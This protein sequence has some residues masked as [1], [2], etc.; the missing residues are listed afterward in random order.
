VETLSPVAPIDTLGCPMAFSLRLCRQLGSRF[1]SPRGHLVTTTSS[2]GHESQGR[3]AP[4]NLIQQLSERFSRTSRN[5][6]RG[7][8]KEQRSRLCRI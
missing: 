7:S 6:T 3:F 4:I 2:G 1:A 5:E 8:R